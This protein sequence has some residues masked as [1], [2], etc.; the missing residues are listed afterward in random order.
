MREKFMSKIIADDKATGKIT[1]APRL[2]KTRSTGK[3][4]ER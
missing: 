2:K 4:A 1:R 3:K